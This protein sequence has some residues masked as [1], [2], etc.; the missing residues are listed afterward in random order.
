MGMADL[1][2][3]GIRVKMEEDGIACQGVHTL[4]GGIAVAG[5]VGG[6]SCVELWDAG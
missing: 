3:P 6:R 1:L 5:P 4:A 2:L